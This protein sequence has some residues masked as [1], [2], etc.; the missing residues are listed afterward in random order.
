MGTASLFFRPGPF[1]SLDKTLP[2]H[3]Y[4][5]GRDTADPDQLNCFI[6]AANHGNGEAPRRRFAHSPGRSA[7][8]WRAAFIKLCLEG[9]YEEDFILPALALLPGVAYAENAFAPA[10]TNGQLFAPAK[11][12]KVHEAD[13][14]DTPARPSRSPPPGGSARKTETRS[15]SCSGRTAIPCRSVCSRRRGPSAAGN[16]LWRR[17]LRPG[18]L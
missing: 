12:P 8:A 13:P 5:P 9:C 15:A 1:A 17:S 11:A 2:G 14:T 7:K 10:D 18:L 4:F 16:H 3:V 6:R